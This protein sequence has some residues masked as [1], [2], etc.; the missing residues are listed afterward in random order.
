MT[1][2]IGAGLD[3]GL[4]SDATGGCIVVGSTDPLPV[5]EV[6][7][8][9]ERRPQRGAPLVPSVVVAEFCAEVKH[10]G[11][12]AVAVDQF[13][14]ESVR[15][16]VRKAGLHLYESPSG[17]AGKVQLYTSTR[18][19]VHS[20]RVRF[21]AGQKRLI[22]Q[23]RE[24]MSVPLPGGGIRISSP[25]R[26]GSHGDLVSAFVL[27]LWRAEVT[28][29]AS[30]SS[31]ELFVVPSPRSFSDAQTPAP[32]PRRDYSKSYEERSLPFLRD[33]RGGR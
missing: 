24:V 3:L 1:R 18:E 8:V 19:L 30:G 23:L 4:R 13:Y 29:R 33:E 22:Q 31:A 32:R 5:F 26:R 28:A 6:A 15:E 10:Y 25:R 16:H 14:I 9:F 21:A 12:K 27:A 11:G 17:N 2:V 20:G 7:L